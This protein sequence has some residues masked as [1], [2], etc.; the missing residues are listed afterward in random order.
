MDMS[1]RRRE[2]GRMSVVV[3]FGAASRSSV[4]LVA[5]SRQVSGDADREREIGIAVADLK[6]SD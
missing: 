2:S 4:L 1:T 6:A 3:V 5:V